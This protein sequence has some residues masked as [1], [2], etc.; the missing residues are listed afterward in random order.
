MDRVLARRWLAESGFTAADGGGW[1]SDGEVSSANDLVH[2]VTGSIMVDGDLTPAE[3]VRTGFGLLDLTGEGW[4]LVEIG[5]GLKAMKAPEAD[6]MFWICCRRRLEA[7]EPCEPVQYR[8]WVDWFEHD[9]TVERAFAEVLGNDVSWLRGH[10][11][12]GRVTQDPRFR[13]ADRVLRVTGPVPWAL[14]LPV[15]QA[16]RTS[17]ELHPAI[18]Q[19]LLTSYHDVYGKLEPAPALAVLEGLDLPPD[20][21]HLGRLR[22]VLRGG[23]ENHYRSPEAWHA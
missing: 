19:G 15:Y 14:K 5:W 13:R 11:R 10:D 2:M 23:H 22:T 8:L 18:F 7:P 1:E 20:T 4:V 3:R 9:D 16:A 17:R 6:E 21:E 12:R